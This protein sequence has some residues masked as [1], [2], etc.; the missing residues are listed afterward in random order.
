MSAQS[1]DHKN[2]G[3]LNAMIKALE[4]LKESRPSL[5]FV[6]T[7]VSSSAIPG[8]LRDQEIVQESNRTYTPTP[9]AF[10]TANTDRLKAPIL[11]PD[12]QKRALK[13]S[14]KLTLIKERSVKKQQIQSQQ[15]L[16]APVRDDKIGIK[17]RQRRHRY[18][19]WHWL[20]ELAIIMSKMSLFGLFLILTLLGSVFF[21][22]GFLAAVSNVQEKGNNNPSWQQASACH[23]GNDGSGK[24]NPFLKAASGIASTLVDQKVASIESKLGGGALNKVIE[25]VPPSLQPFALQMQNKFAQQSQSVVSSGGRAIKGG[26]KPSRFG[27]TPPPP[28]PAQIASTTPSAYHQVFGSP[29]PQ[30]QTGPAQPASLQKLSPAQMS[31]QQAGHVYDKAVAPPAPMPQQGYAQPM[32]AQQPQPNGYI[33]PQQAYTNP[34]YAQPPQHPQAYQQ[35]QAPVMSQP[36]GAS[37]PYGYSQVPPQEQPRFVGMG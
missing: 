19:L 27:G 3:D 2:L 29:Q 32:Y 34:G 14:K 12:K 20:E 25:K 11:A 13:K 8:F 37:Q 9:M 35:Q 1:V 4:R 22:V 31:F 10:E 23:T 24:P 18:G 7:G 30:Q 5:S 33:Q 26:F 36:Y 21:G 15:A 28:P 6:K 17:T 16:N